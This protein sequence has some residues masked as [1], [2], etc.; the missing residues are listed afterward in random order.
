MTAEGEA[1][2]TPVMLDL[3]DLHKSYTPGRPVLAGVSLSV[4][5]GEIVCL[6]GPSGSGKTTLLRVV[7]GLEQPDSGQV[8][9]NGRDLARVPV[10]KRSFGM[11]FQEYALFPHRTVAQNIAFGLRMARQPAGEIAARVAEMLDLVN[12]E[13]Y[14]GRT[15]FEL[16]G[17]ERQR[18]ALARSLAPH[19]TLLMLDEPLGSL[20]RSLR[21]ALMG[22]LRA[23]LKRVGVTALYVTHDQEEAFAVGDRIVILNE[24]KIAQQGPAAEVIATPASAFVARFLGFHNLLPAEVLGEEPRRA[25]TAVGSLPLDAPAAPGAYTLLLRPHAARLDPQGPL[26]AAVRTNMFRGDIYR[27]QFALAGAER[28]GG[29]EQSLT[30]DLPAAGEAA[31][32][33]PGDAVRLALDPGALTLLPAAGG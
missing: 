33:M 20:D 12:L 4:A 22:E 26:T 11:M 2:Q 29:G 32:L 14:G 1:R 25:Q 10:H 8:L 6:L 16:S 19:P 27:V 31:A 18:V 30:F 17:G 3:I 23:I 21:E 5:S 24:G 9:C 7:A 15:I 28:D 13:G